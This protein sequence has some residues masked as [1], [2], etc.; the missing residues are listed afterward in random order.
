MP[1]SKECIEPPPP[2]SD[3]LKSYP[4][5]HYPLQ[6]QKVLIALAQSSLPTAAGSQMAGIVGSCLTGLDSRDGLGGG[7]RLSDANPE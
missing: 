6:V 2:S 4:G 3:N 7:L 1:L 5:T